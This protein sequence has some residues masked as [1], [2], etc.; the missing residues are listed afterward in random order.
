VLPNGQIKLA[1]IKAYL[2]QA[3]AGEMIGLTQIDYR[4]WKV[5]FNGHSLSL[6]DG[7]KGKM[8]TT[9]KYYRMCNLCARSKL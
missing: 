9:P 5:H 2:S 7:F 8:V 1:G 3:M 4:Y 6:L